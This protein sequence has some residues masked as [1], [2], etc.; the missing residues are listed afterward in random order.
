[1]HGPDDSVGKQTPLRTARR[2]ADATRFIDRFAALTG[3]RASSDSAHSLP[4]EFLTRPVASPEV[5]L[6]EYGV[7]LELRTRNAL[8]RFEP[9]RPH[10]RW[11]FGRLLE[12]RGFGVFSLLDLLAVMARH[13]GTRNPGEP[14]P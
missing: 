12:I 13:G 4:R 1:M 5:L 9:V 2:R 7:E 10:E 14:G 3:L 8:C 6:R 11:T